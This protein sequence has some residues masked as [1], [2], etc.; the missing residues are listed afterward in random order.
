[1]VQRQESDSLCEEFEDSNYKRGSFKTRDSQNI[2][3]IVMFLWIDLR[4]TLAR[5]MQPA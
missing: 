3:I 4:S 2:L 5:A 1:M